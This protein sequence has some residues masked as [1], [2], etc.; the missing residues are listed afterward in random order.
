MKKTKT[1]GTG[2]YSKRISNQ[3]NAY[4]QVNLNSNSLEAFFDP[5]FIDNCNSPDEQEGL[6]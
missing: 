2:M 4:S 1:I 5:L 6:C 3:L